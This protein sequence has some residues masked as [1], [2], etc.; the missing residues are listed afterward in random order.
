MSML[1]TMGLLGAS[2]LVTFLVACGSSN[3]ST[4]TSSSSSSSTTASSSSSSSSSSSGTGGAGGGSCVTEMYKKYGGQATFHKVTGDIITKAAGDATVGKFFTAVAADPA[5]LAAFSQNLED[6][7]VMVYG[8]PNNYKGKDMKTAH[9][10]LAITSSDYD[11]FVTSV[12]VPVLKTDGVSDADI[13]NCFAPPVVDPA[14]KAS[15]VGQ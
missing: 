5:K 14:L 10:G 8:G 3:S 12:I 11:Y 9:K 15:I 2:G 1:R 7:L 13:M 4:S 6:F